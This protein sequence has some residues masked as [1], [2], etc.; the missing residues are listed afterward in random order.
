MDNEWEHAEKSEVK[1]KHLLPK[2]IT[3]T[4]VLS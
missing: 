3:I 2:T 4:I 1:W